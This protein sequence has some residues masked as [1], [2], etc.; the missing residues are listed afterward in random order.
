MK[1]QP[2]LNYYL[3]V[4]RAGGKPLL[5]RHDRWRRTAV[6]LKLS[7]TAKSRLEW[8]VFYETKNK[9]ASLTA[10][11]FGI[12]RKT[13]HHWLSRFD[14]TNLRTLEERSRAPKKCREREY[15]PL[16][17]E[18]VVGLRRTHIRYG[19]LKLLALYHQAF[20]GDKNLSSWNIQCIIERSGIYYNPVKQARQ[21]RKRVLSVKRKK[22]TDLTKKPVTGFLVCLDTVRS[23]CTQPQAVH[24]HSH[25]QALQTRFR[26]DVYHTFL[27]E[28]DR[29]LVSSP[30][31]T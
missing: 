5:S 26:S 18:R 31:S 24:P 10:R 1:I 15:T 2:Y 11:H 30:L 16:Q 7:K 21:N 28:C 29:L 3:P 8:M 22:I 12:A 6:L 19:K 14:E 20:P 27:G 23:V 9:H 17:Y 4:V 13:F 25:R